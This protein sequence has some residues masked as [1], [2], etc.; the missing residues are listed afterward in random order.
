MNA[1][2]A[3]SC[4]LLA[5]GHLACT[6][7][8]AVDYPYKPYSEGKLDPQPSGWPLSPAELLW[9]EQPEYS[10]K[11]GHEAHKHLPEMWPVTPTAGHWKPKAEGDGNRWLQNH[12]TLV[13]LVQAAKGSVDVALLGDS[14]TQAWG[15]GWNQ[16]P[17]NPAW[18]G[19]FPNLKMLNL[20]IGGDRT[21]GILWRLEHGALDGVSPRIIVLLIG[22]NNAPLVTANGIPPARVAE[23]IHLCVGNLRER[24]PNSQIVVVKTLPG[25]AHQS[26][27]HAD[28]QRIN[29]AVETLKL[30]SDPFVHLLDLWTDF[31]ESDGSLKKA[32]YAG[33]DLH[34]SNAGYE[35]YASRLQPLLEKLF[36][37]Q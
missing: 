29:S 36:S 31:T 16:A 30:D 33:D 21:E 11:P 3:A 20:G 1:A 26:T 22:V 10:R 37:K 7:V 24:C 2:R 9:V 13:S 25:F 19:R 8:H 5:I 18:A 14:I 4:L 28:I 34:L 6:S 12:Q 32:A 15:G 35:I 23:G 17:V 27:V